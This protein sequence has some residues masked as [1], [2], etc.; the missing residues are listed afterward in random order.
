MK[1]YWQLSLAI[2]DHHHALGEVDYLTNLPLPQSI[3]EQIL[4]RSA[5]AA[6]QARQSEAKLALVAAQHDLGQ[7]AAAGTTNPL[8]TDIPYVGRYRTNFA[9]IF[10]SQPAPS[11]LRRIDR[12]L[13]LFHELIDARA[14]S[15]VTAGEALM[16]LTSRYEQ[17]QEEM[18][19]LITAFLQLR[20]QRIALLASIR[21]YNYSIADY[22]L[23]VASPGISREAIVAMLIETTPHS[24]SVLV[25][26]RSVQPVAA[27]APVEQELVPVQPA[28]APTEAP[29]TA[30]SPPTI[31]PPA[32]F[33]PQLPAIPIQGST[34]IPQPIKIAPTPER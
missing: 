4:L 26:R 3:H 20:Q 15:V 30:P 5:V 7:A 2:A 31:Q 25:P 9:E 18:A 24:R 19:T 28:T 16:A 29:A 13:P 12:T 14:S 34:F 6:A 17:G 21:D 33:V 11:A 27:E 22:A 1:A 32:R 8:P 23:S 10:A